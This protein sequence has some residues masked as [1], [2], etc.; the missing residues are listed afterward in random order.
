MSLDFPPLK[1]NPGG[2][3]RL[4]IHRSGLVAEEALAT[5]WGS[6][7]Q[8]TLPFLFFCGLQ[9]MQLL[10]NSLQIQDG[11]VKKVQTNFWIMHAITLGV[12]VHEI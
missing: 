5:I 1:I 4:G 6:L 2:T 7:F 10:T 11:R 12:R 3:S 9:N 8:C